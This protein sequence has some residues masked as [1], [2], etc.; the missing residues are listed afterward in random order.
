MGKAFVER[1]EERTLL[2][3]GTPV[4]VGSGAVV[5]ADSVLKL[6][7]TAAVGKGNTVIITVATTAVTGE[8]SVQDTANKT[9]YAKDADFPL[10]TDPT[11]SIRVLVFSLTLMCHWPR[12]LK[13][14]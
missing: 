13:S 1:L 3:I 12:L 8:I 4:L 11:A 5:D 9:L 10:S 7:P 2:S 14:M 6:N